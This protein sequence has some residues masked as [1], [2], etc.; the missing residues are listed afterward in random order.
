MNTEM[1]RKFQT[2]ILIIEEDVRHDIKYRL[3][4]DVTQRYAYIRNLLTANGIEQDLAKGLAS[5][6][7]MT[8]QRAVTK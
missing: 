5:A 4:K 8:M 3:Y 2:A 7:I 1:I 6:I